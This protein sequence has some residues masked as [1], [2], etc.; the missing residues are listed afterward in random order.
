MS[1]LCCISSLEM[2]MTLVASV[3]LPQSQTL[4][5]RSCTYERATAMLVPV[6]ESA[7]SVPVHWSPTLR[8]D[9]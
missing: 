8:T 6:A 4:L 3:E 2:Y 7:R 9:C 5:R 1:S